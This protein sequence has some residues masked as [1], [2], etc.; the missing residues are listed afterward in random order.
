MKVPEP[1]DLKFLSEMA[2]NS[3][4][5]QCAACLRRH[6]FATRM[7]AF[8]T[9]RGILEEE[10]LLEACKAAQ[11]VVGAPEEFLAPASETA[12]R[13]AICEWRGVLYGGPS[14]LVGRDVKEL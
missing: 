5:C 9:R 4:G 12:I 6:G 13:E 7:L 3:S 1:D 2:G 8:F 10:A 11:I 14:K